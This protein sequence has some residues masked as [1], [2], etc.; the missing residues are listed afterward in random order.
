MNELGVGKV[1][2]RPL[3]ILPTCP[4]SCPDIGLKFLHRLPH[5]RLESVQDSLFPGQGIEQR[6][7]FRSMEVDVIS[8]CAVC[9]GPCSQ[10]LARIRIS[11]LAQFKERIPFDL[12]DETEPFRPLTSPPTNN[13]ILGV[14]VLPGEALLEVA[15]GPKSRSLLVNP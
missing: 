5:S 8:D 12:S 4:D 10:H 13:C 6:H 15:L 14:I 9:P 3:R 11:I 1:A 2:G 7:R